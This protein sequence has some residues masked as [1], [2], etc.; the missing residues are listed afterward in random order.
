[1]KAIVCEVFGRPEVLALRD[2]PDPPPPGAGETH[3]RIAAHSVQY[4]EALMLI[5][6][7]VMVS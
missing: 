3:V 7:A 4:V 1:M 6:K 2:V 5:G